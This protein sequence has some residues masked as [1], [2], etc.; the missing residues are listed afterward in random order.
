MLDPFQEIELEKPWLEGQR[1]LEHACIGYCDC[2]ADPKADPVIDS[3]TG[4]MADIEADTGSVM[5]WLGPTDADLNEGL[6]ELNLD[7]LKAIEAVDF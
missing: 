7:G 4:K 5:E 1:R 3:A 2:G 6:P